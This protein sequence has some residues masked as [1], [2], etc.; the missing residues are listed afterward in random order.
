MSNYYILRHHGIK[1]Q[2]W[3]I[4]RTPE[5]LGRHVYSRRSKMSIDEYKHACDLWRKHHEIDY[6]PDPK[7]RVLSSFTNNLSSDEKEVSST[8]PLLLKV[9]QGKIP[10]YFFGSHL[11]GGTE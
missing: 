10:N 11:I 9:I 6:W 1:G 8:V 3:G 5:E 2:R 4:R 7:S